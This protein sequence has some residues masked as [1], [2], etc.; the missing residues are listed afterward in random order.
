MIAMYRFKYA[1]QI[2]ITKFFLT[3]VVIPCSF[4]LAL[5]TG[6][7]ATVSV[8]LSDNL[9]ILDSKARSGM[10]ELINLGA[11]PTEFRL[12]VDESLLGT[13]TDA[14]SM[15]R[16]APARS[17]VPAHQTRP[18][19]ISARP[20]PELAPGE[21]IFRVGVTC[22]AKPVLR[23]PKAGGEEIVEDG[24]AVTIPIVPTLPITVYLR[25]DIEPPML[26]VES[27][28][29]TPED[30]AVM[31]YFPVR[32]KNPEYSFVGQVQV[33]E[34]QSKKIINSGRLHL[35][36]GKPGSRVNMPRPETPLVEGTRYCV[37][38]W[39]HFPGE[40]EPLVE[41]CGQ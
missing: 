23:K 11:D 20:T 35:S 4:V 10:I 34:E 17:Q 22:E 29:L 25:H 28:V 41:S 21:Y 13:P 24:I 36:P 12:K 16:W 38:V 8:A 3:G 26:E 37:R 9:V 14:S 15:L 5:V 27:L 31:G 6:V 40:G 2:N 1:Q 19:R 7:E 32:K 33:V 30:T 39:D 18:V